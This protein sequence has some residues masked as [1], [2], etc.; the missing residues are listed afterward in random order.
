MEE[1]WIDST[2]YTTKPDGE[3]RLAVEMAV[4]DLL[5]DLDIPYWRLD[6][7]ATPSIEA[8]RQVDQRLGIKLC[9]NLFLCNTQKTRFY[10]LLMPGE[11]RFRTK[12]LSKQINSS[13]LSFGESQDM[14]RLLRVAPGSATVLS[15]MNDT[16]KAV[17]LIIDREILKEPYLGCHPCINT[18]SLKIKLD[19]ILNKFLPYTGHRPL[20]VELE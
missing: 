14:E 20:W 12:E 7:D 9:K 3:G 6:H 17:Q 10:L 19:D 2:L 13:R 15:L 5:D 8:C 18:T 16:D 4:Y 1:I 11:K